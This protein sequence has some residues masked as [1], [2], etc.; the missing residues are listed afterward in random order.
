MLQRW[1]LLPNEGESLYE[2]EQRRSGDPC[3]P[4]RSLLFADDELTTLLATGYAMNTYP[5]L[6][7]YAV[8]AVTRSIN[9]FRYNDVTTP[10]FLWWLHTYI[11]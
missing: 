9:A 5:S 2:Y 10:L 4:A 7:T 3:T 6:S 8:Q 11:D 1:E